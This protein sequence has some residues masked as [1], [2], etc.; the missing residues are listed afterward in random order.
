VCVNVAACLWL[1]ACLPASAHCGIAWEVC[2]GF[3]LLLVWAKG[4]WGV[5]PDLSP[6]T[7]VVV[8]V[9]G[10]DRAVCVGVRVV[11]VLPLVQCTWGGVHPCMVWHRKQREPTGFT[12]TWQVLLDPGFRLKAVNPNPCWA[13]MSIMALVMTVWHGEECRQNLAGRQIH[14]S[15]ALHK[16]R[17]GG[18]GKFG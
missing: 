7:A 1:S 11:H 15:P 3:R 14:L 4:R 10:E 2:A 16:L 12:G 17:A 5:V 9:G 13:V 8:I 18:M 6:N